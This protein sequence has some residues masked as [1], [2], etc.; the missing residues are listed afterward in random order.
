MDRNRVTG[1]G[2]QITAAL[3]RRP[4]V[5]DLSATALIGPEGGTIELPQTGLRL[6][7]PADVVRKPTPFRVTARAGRLV[8]YDFE[9]EGSEFSPAL[10]FEQDPAL[11]EPPPIRADAPMRMQLGYYQ[12]PSDLDEHRGVATVSEVHHLLDASSAQGAFAVPHF[13]DYVVGWG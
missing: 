2:T 11:L 4:L 5:R 10:R 3:W 13:S 6:V 9:P 1:D 7:V 12:D 8:A